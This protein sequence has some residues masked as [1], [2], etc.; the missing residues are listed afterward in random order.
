MELATDYPPVPGMWAIRAQDALDALSTMVTAEEVTERFGSA[1]ALTEAV[2]GA[3]L[4][5]GAATRRAVRATGRLLTHRLGPSLAADALSWAATYSSVLSPST[6]ELFLESAGGSEVVHRALRLEDRHPLVEELSRC[7]S[8]SARRRMLLGLWRSLSEDV[9]HLPECL[10]TCTELWDWLDIPAD[11][12][13]ACDWLASLDPHGT[14]RQPDIAELLDAGPADQLTV[15]MRLG[16]QEHWEIAGNHQLFELDETVVAAC[17]QEHTSAVLHNATCPPALRKLIRHPHDPATLELALRAGPVNFE[18]ARVRQLLADIGPQLH[19]RFLAELPAAYLRALRICGLMT[20]EALIDGPLVEV[21]L[22]DL[23]IGQAALGTALTW[24]EERLPAMVAE[25]LIRHPQARHLTWVFSEL[26]PGKVSST[27]AHS[28]VEQACPEIAVLALRHL[29]TVELEVSHAPLARAGSDYWTARCPG[30]AGDERPI[31]TGLDPLERIFNDGHLDIAEG[32]APQRRSDR[33]FR[34]PALI[35]SLQDPY[36]EAPGWTVTLPDSSAALDRNARRMRNCTS[37]YLPRIL[38]GE[39]YVLIIESP[40]GGC[41]N[42]A[43]RRVGGTGMPTYRT[44]E[45]NGRANRGEVPC[46]I[47][48]AIDA[49]LQL[50]G[51]TAAADEPPTPP[52][53]NTDRRDRR[54]AR[55]TRARRR[56]R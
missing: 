52:R 48:P 53:R 11:P 28:L 32:S 14:P 17:L 2:L 20:A 4:A 27:L 47:A 40:A 44:G 36:P 12:G 34:Y 22:S 30:L 13:A 43:V 19:S 3:P 21:D 33:P 38:D 45:I 26:A 46:W 55:A 25:V 37:S 31:R 5:G 8:E 39:C 50:G 9:A 16:V 6:I 56:R 18:H 41:Y 1:R 24:P 15:Y 23:S 51:I 35:E 49:R 42:A 54:R 7:R 29:P 10:P